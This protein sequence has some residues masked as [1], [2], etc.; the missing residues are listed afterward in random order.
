MTGLMLR[1]AA[2]SIQAILVIGVVFVLRKLF[3]LVPVSKKYVMILWMIVYF[4]LVFPWKVSVPEGF[5]NQTAISWHPGDGKSG[6]NDEKKNLDEPHLDMAPKQQFLEDSETIQNV[7]NLREQQDHKKTEHISDVQDGRENATIH[8]LP[9]LSDLW[10]AFH[11]LEIKMLDAANGNGQVTARVLCAVWVAGILFFVLRGVLSYARL[12]RCVLCSVRYEQEWDH[13]ILGGR[14]NLAVYEADGILTPIVLGYFRPCIYFPSDMDAAYKEY[15]AVHEWTHIQRKDYLTKTAAYVITCLHWFNPVVWLAYYFMTRDME[16]ACDEETVYKIGTDQ[17]K[18]YAS[19]LLAL[20]VAQQSHF[21]VPPAFGD[22]SMKARI[23]NIMRYKKTAKITAVFVVAAGIFLTGIFLTADDNS[24]PNS[25]KKEQD[26]QKAAMLAEDTELQN[27]KILTFE[28]VREAF[29]QKN[30]KQLNFRQYHNGQ[31]FINDELDEEEPYDMFDYYFNFQNETYHMRASFLKS[32]NQ[33]ENVCISRQSDAQM[34]YIYTIDEKGRES[35]PYNL[36]VFLR[37][38]TKVDEWLTIELPEGYTIG[39]Y[40]A[41]LGFSGGILIHP[42]SYSTHKEMDS[43][44]K[45]WKYAGFIGTVEE[46]QDVFVFED[47]KLDQRYYPQSNH[48]H[49][50]PIGVI[51]TISPGFGWKTLLVHSFHDLYTGGEIGALEMEGVDI[52]KLETQSEYWD[53]YFVKEG[54]NR[55]HLLSLSAKEFDRTEAMAIARTVVMMEDE[56]AK[57]RQQEVLRTLKDYFQDFLC[58]MLAE[59]DRKYT[60]KDFA[61]IDGYIAWKWLEWRR[62]FYRET[63]GGIVSVDLNDVELFDLTEKEHGLEALANISYQYAWG[64]SEDNASN[65]GSLFRIILEPD[66]DQWQVV[67]LEYCDCKE[68][69]ILK[70]LMEREKIAAADGYDFIDNYFQ[71]MIQKTGM[72]SAQILQNRTP[73]AEVYA[74]PLID[75]DENRVIFVNSRGMVIYNRKQQSV[76]AVIDL[77]KIGCNYFTVDSLGTKIIAKDNQIRIFNTKDNQVT[78][79]CYVYE[80]SKYTEKAELLEPVKVTKAED[81]LL[82]EWKEKMNGR[83]YDSFDYLGSETVSGWENGITQYSKD[84]LVWTKQ[85]ERCVSC[86]LL[87]DGEYQLYTRNENTGKAVTEPL[88]IAVS[89][90]EA[91]QAEDANALPEFVYMGEDKILKTICDYMAGEE[92]ATA[93]RKTVSSEIFIP[94]PVIYDMIRED[95]EIKV[96]GNFYSF[97]YYKNGNTLEEDGGS[98][99]PAC[100]HLKKTNGSYD[101]VDVEKTGDGTYYQK[102]IEKFCQGHPHIYEKFLDH[103]KTMELY[104]QRKRMFIGQYVKDH[105]LDILYYH[106]FGW[107]PVELFTE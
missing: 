105:Q 76:M 49:D 38:K 92:K 84:A 67:D 28:M 15:V 27:Q 87:R 2:M 31:L 35:Y 39:S 95:G 34:A 37:T 17:K 58:T 19:A 45:H 21:A 69:M 29:A 3:A 101:V 88:I 43:A 18:A 12:K 41:D 106:E 89:R 52:S 93:S 13:E 62:E 102:G 36:E 107:D 91:K 86:L 16:M 71:Q 46:P 94:I 98:E 59:D 81:R 68:I 82:D 5:W 63:Y 24:I 6:N 44:P 14:K 9:K 100:F 33:L 65:A 60:R 99:M 4:F 42:Q 72:E 40:N 53:F 48:S 25:A 7:Q 23:Q 1:I 75:C 20:S 26:L 11:A 51:D 104:H 80:L 77:Q 85:G 55:A 74:P 73:E 66:G 61:G 47:G 90:Q 32:S 22:G 64:K 97:M 83:Y 103:E 8:R 10:K 50:E 30:V 56:A 54:E 78:G 79:N 96:F 57:Q 70:E